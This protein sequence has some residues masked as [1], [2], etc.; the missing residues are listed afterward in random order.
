MAAGLRV[1]SPATGQT[2]A[3]GSGEAKKTTLSWGGVGSYGS[4]KDGKLLAA[5]FAQA[6]NAVAGQAGAL[7][8]ARPAAAQSNP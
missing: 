5:A 2:L 8:A 3:A 4:S 6:Y 7:A 1:T